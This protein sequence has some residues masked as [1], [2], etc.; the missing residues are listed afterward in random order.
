[1]RSSAET[2]EVVAVRLKAKLDKLET[3]VGQGRVAVAQA[4]GVPVDFLPEADQ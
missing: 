4:V 3:E 2:V 1:M